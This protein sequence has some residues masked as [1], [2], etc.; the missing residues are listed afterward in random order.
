[1]LFVSSNRLPSGTLQYKKLKT[2]QKKKEEKNLA[3]QQATS[4]SVRSYVERTLVTVP[5][6]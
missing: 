5:Q 1:M 4:L 6:A 3:D 2:S